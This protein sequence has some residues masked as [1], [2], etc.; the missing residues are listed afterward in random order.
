MSTTTRPDRVTGSPLRVAMAA[1]LLLQATPGCADRNAYP[2]PCTSVPVTVL[3]A[4]RQTLRA[5]PAPP[6]LIDVDPESDTRIEIGFDDMEADLAVRIREVPMS[7]TGA[8][9]LRDAVRSATGRR[10]SCG[11]VAAST[12]SPCSTTKRATRPA[13]PADSGSSPT[14]TCSTTTAR[15]IRQADRGTGRGL[16][17]N[18]RRQSINRFRCARSPRASRESTFRSSAL[19]LSRRRKG[20]RG[21]TRSASS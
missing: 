8:M 2:S 9:A 12:G 19:P 20:P 16:A 14:A 7:A 11:T 6:A 3:E 13:R 5:D 15:R 1:V 10:T 17:A 4:R 18:A 21:R